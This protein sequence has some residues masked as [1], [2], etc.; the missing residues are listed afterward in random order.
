[1]LYALGSNGGGQLGLSHREDCHAPVAVPTKLCSAPTSFSA[2]GNHSC[3]VVNNKLYVSGVSLV[4]EPGFQIIPGEWK[5]CASTWNALIAVD[6]SN[7]VYAWGAGSKG[8]L[9][10]GE[11]QQTKGF[12]KVDIHDGEI[13]NIVG[14]MEHVVILYAD[15]DAFG[16]GS[17][18]K[19]QLGEPAASVISRP[20]RL[21]GLARTAACGRECTILIGLDD[22]CTI[23]GSEKHSMHNIPHSSIHGWKQLRTSWR[24]V[25]LLC[26]D[27]TI[28]SWGQNDRGQFAPPDLPQP[29]AELASGS[30]H[31]VAIIGKRVYAWGW[32]E[33]GNLGTDG[34]DVSHAQTI[35][36]PGCPTW[37]GAGCATT[38]VYTQDS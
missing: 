23:M 21:K 1:M 9:G 14:S 38:F 12:V 25:H 37:V 17:G 11:I 20:R 29:V 18:R 10:L 7:H 15:G 28:I 22:Q 36:V 6:V 34:K 33:H 30:E 31:A 35:P 27:G 3:L 32:G 19:G 13:V 5:L 8:E 4:D 2:G 16:W 24:T 26:N